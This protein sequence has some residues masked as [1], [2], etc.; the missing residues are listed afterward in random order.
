MKK[1]LFILTVFLIIGI[2]SVFSQRIY[3][4]KTDNGYEQPIIDKLISEGYQITFKQDSA[5][6]MVKCIIGKTGMGRAKG[7]VAI[8]D[9]KSGD[10]LAKTKDV[11]GQTAITNGYANP[12]MV[13]MKKIAD[14]YL[15][16]L[17]RKYC[18]EK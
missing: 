18:K 10:L 3:V 7:S 15:I 9:N 16:D 12:K 2:T 8:I 6:Y 5:D 4:E 1:R 11:N 17:V 13:A 14:K